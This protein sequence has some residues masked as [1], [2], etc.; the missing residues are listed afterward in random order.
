MIAIRTN[1][2]KEV[3]LGHIFRMRILAKELSKKSKLIFFLDKYDEL[4]E[5]F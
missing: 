5:K 4:I 2:N 3:G 1:F